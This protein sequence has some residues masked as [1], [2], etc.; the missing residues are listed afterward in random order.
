MHIHRVDTVYNRRCYFNRPAGRVHWENGLLTK[1]QDGAIITL[2]YNTAP[3]E[4]AI[5]YPP[6][7]GLTNCGADTLQS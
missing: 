4:T 3:E 6:L 2:G 5:P 7:C 1:M